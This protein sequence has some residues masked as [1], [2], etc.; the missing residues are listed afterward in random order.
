MNRGGSQT[1]LK[2]FAPSLGTTD[3]TRPPWPSLITQAVTTGFHTLSSVIAHLRELPFFVIFFL[4]R[5]H[6]DNLTFVNNQYLVDQLPHGSVKNY[7]KGLFPADKDIADPVFRFA[8][9]AD[10]QY[11]EQHREPC[12]SL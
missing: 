9:S 7:Y 5:Y 4:F 3:S 2:L 6:P 12:G 11:N 8:S 1:R 10:L